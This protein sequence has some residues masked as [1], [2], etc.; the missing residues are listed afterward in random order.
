MT[1]EL[2]TTYSTVMNELTDIRK[3]LL[4]MGHHLSTNDYFNE[5]CYDEDASIYSIIQTYDGEIVLFQ[6][7]GRNFDARLLYGEME[8]DEYL[9][10]LPT[11]GGAEPDPIAYKIYQQECSARRRREWKASG[12]YYHGIRE[13]YN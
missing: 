12:D 7:D 1:T 3:N 11:E 5:E 2:R 10:C 4:R 6:M 13:F 9:E 8:Y